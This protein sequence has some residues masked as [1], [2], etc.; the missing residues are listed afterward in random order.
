MQNDR[1]HQ[2]EAKLE[3]LKRQLIVINIRLNEY[4]SYDDIVARCNA[5]SPKFVEIEELPEPPV[6]PIIPVGI[7]ITGGDMRNTALSEIWLQSLCN[8]CSQ[9][10]WGLMVQNGGLMVHRK[11]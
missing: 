10:R 4:I 5:L 8:V 11:V 1:T 7:Y 3:D 6:I 2:D 9:D